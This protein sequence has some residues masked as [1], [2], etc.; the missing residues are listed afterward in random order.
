MRE[1][2]A[3]RSAL[4]AFLAI[5]CLLFTLASLDAPGTEDVDL[6]KFWMQNVSRLGLRAGYEATPDSYPPGAFAILLGVTKVAAALGVRRFLVFKLT[7][8]LFLCAT[9]LVFWLWTR[10]RTLALA[11][12]LALALNSVALGYLDILVAPSLVA[13]LWALRRERWALAGLCYALSLQPKWQPAILGPFVVLWVGLA[14]PCGLGPA[15]RRLAAFAAP[16][17]AVAGASFLAVG[18]AYPKSLLHATGH[19]YLS[20]NALNA[21]WLVGYGLRAWRPEVYGGLSS[22]PDALKG[23]HLILDTRD[24]ALVVPLRLAFLGLYALALAL[25][26]RRGRGFGD[27]LACALLGYVGYFAFATGAHENHLFLAVLVAAALAGV[28]PGRWL[29][30]AGWAAAANL[31]LWTFYGLEGSVPQVAGIVGLSLIFALMNLG[32]VAAGVLALLR[33]RGTGTSPP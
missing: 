30:F 8:V 27:F 1:G 23:E 9:A 3:W 7:L 14:A 29:P 26:A 10:N 19:S 2:G 12:Y 18:A 33:S 32:L 4:D 5:A 25:L 28:E 22:G 20:G 31:N 16:A 6:W 13:A 24:P 21:P 17:L 15:I 11:L